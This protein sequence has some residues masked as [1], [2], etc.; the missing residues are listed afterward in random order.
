MPTNKQLNFQD[1]ATIIK[2]AV[3]KQGLNYANF[4]KK[5]HMSESGLKKLMI[6]KDCSFNKL[7]KICKV[8]N[9]DFAKIVMLAAN[10][11]LGPTSLT[12]EQIEFLEKSDQALI[13]LLNL[14]IF[15]YE[16]EF[17]EKNMKIPKKNLYPL[18]RKLEKKGF[19]EWKPGDKVKSKSPTHFDL[20]RVRNAGK[21]AE[22]TVRQVEVEFAKF[23]PS[24][25]ENAFCKTVMANP[26]RRDL[27]IEMNRKIRELMKEYMTETHRDWR[28]HP[29]Q[30]M[31]Y[32]AWIYGA[33]PVDIS[34]LI[35]SI[36]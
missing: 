3:R 15:D 22:K 26:I 30:D 20:N 23:Q 29:K 5:L 31:V 28:F 19:I 33:M 8:L 11:D 13:L 18:L 10:N 21:L 7:G 27:L 25:E 4:A 24:L 35:P 2:E 6:G 17:L 12:G 1:I 9:L 34:K 14:Q 16:L 36:S 32:T